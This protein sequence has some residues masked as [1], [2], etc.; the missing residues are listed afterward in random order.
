MAIYP[1]CVDDKNDVFWM[2]FGFSNSGGRGGRIGSKVG[3]REA[4]RRAEGHLDG[5][6]KAP[7]RAEGFLDVPPYLPGRANNPLHGQA[8]EP[9]GKNGSTNPIY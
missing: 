4:P 9:T 3:T 1:V 5:Q 6:E 8:F 7:G 2:G